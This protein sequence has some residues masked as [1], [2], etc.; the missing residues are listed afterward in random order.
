MFTVNGDLV[1]QYAEFVGSA[2]TAF[3]P[4]LAAVIGVF[5]AFAIADRLRFFIGRI[6]KK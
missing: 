6:I 1:A 3:L 2:M 4:L 5:V